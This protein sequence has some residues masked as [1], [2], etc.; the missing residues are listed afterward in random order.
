VQSLDANP[1]LNAVSREGWELITA[2]F[3]TARQDARG[4][5]QHSSDSN[6]AV[7]DRTIGYYLF[8]RCQANQR[9]PADPF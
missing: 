7:P 1:V 5:K 9:Q 6:G 8:R 3:V 4:E 2:S